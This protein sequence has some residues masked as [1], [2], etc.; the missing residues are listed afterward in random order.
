MLVDRD[1]HVKKKAIVSHYKNVETDS[2]CVIKQS[3]CLHNVRSR[4]SH[5]QVWYTLTHDAHVPCKS[6]PSQRW[7]KS[8]GMFCHWSR[9]RSHHSRETL[10]L[11]FEEIGAKAFD[12]HNRHARGYTAVYSIQYAHLPTEVRTHY[13]YVIDA[14][15]QSTTFFCLLVST[16]NFYFRK[17]RK[18]SLNEHE[19][20]LELSSL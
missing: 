9:T 12:W 2:R 1:E 15:R 3:P 19:A 18:N 10:A 8:W 20:E 16:S 14:R 17:Q 7:G 6:R 13:T 11:P 4:V 5:L